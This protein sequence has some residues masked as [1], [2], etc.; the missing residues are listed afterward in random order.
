MAGGLFS[1]PADS[2][3]R[4]GAE[5]REGGSPGTFAPQ[6]DVT[7]EYVGQ[8][9]QRH[10]RVLVEDAARPR[11]DRI[12]SY[13][14]TRRSKRRCLLCRASLHLAVS[15]HVDRTNERPIR[16]FAK[17]PSPAFSRQNPL[18]RRIWHSCHFALSRRERFKISL[19]LGILGVKL[20]LKLG[21]SVSK[22]VPGDL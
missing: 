16:S 13:A 6:G 22:V 19:E 15:G 7:A 3:L 11:L 14:L 10:T 21:S 9:G 8:Q 18:A 17:H 5:G 20:S 2:Q 12:V 4:E 1:H